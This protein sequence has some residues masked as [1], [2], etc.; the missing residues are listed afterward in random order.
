MTKISRRLMTATAM[1]AVLATGA[2]AAMGT[3]Q[4]ADVK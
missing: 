4:A 3:A 1:A 2:F